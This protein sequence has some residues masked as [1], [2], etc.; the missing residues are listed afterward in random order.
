VHVHAVNDCSNSRL[1]IVLVIEAYV[2]RHPINNLRSYKMPNTVKRQ[3][4]RDWRIRSWSKS[5]YFRNWDGTINSPV[6]QRSSHGSVSK[7]E[8]MSTASAWIGTLRTVVQTGSPL[9]TASSI[10]VIGIWITAMRIT[11]VRLRRCRIS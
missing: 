1:L 8:F 5:N 6:L 4:V 2:V 10:G 7:Y 3:L 9:V 11:A